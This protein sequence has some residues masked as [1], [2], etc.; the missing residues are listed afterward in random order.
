MRN[1]IYAPNVAATK[2]CPKLYVLVYSFGIS[3]DAAQTNNPETRKKIP[4]IQV[5]SLRNRDELIFL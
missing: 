1:A 4:D 2:H 5:Q 3:G